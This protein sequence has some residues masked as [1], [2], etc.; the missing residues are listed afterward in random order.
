MKKIVAFLM[1]L[2]IASGLGFAQDAPLNFSIHE[3]IVKP[4]MTTKYQDAVKKLKAACEQNKTS[5][6]WTALVFDDNTH[7][8]VSP[9]PGGLADMEKNP[10]APLEAKIGQEAMGKIWG[11]FS[12]CLETSSD[13]AITRI[14]EASYLSPPAGENARDF[15][16]WFVEPG[17]EGDAMKIMAEW[18]KLYETK[19]VQNGF[20]VYKIMMGK[21]FGYAIMSWGKNPSDIAF[22]EEKS[23]EL[24]GQEA[25][26]LW[27]KT[28]AITRKYFT[29]RAR[30]APELSYVATK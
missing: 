20:A 9:I 17:K 15:L 22:K 30:V 4:S 3:E 14:P 10:F 19:K 23:N 26:A 25:A 1:V 11:E 18:K 5:F 6:S 2:T 28:Q 8:Y 24:L 27:A 21:E 12:G 29:K 13:F 16:Y 7:I